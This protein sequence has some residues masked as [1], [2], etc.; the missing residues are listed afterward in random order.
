MSVQDI[1]RLPVGLEESSEEWFH[2]NTKHVLFLGEYE[3][4]DMSLISG[5]VLVKQ[6]SMLPPGGQSMTRAI[7]S[8]H[9]NVGINISCQFYTSTFSYRTDVICRVLD[10]FKQ[11]Y[12][13]MWDDLI[14]TACNQKSYI[15]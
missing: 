4:F 3:V 13:S 10:I 1:H 15:T 2:I 7:Q 6:S 12:V 5:Y 8:A 11:T 9:S 14:L